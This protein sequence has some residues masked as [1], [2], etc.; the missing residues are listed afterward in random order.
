MY[1]VKADNENDKDRAWE[2]QQRKLDDEYEKQLHQRICQNC[3]N[4]EKSKIKKRKIET[5]IVKK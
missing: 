5:T 2:Y 4:C 3:Q 1:R